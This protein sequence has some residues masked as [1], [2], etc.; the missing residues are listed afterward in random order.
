VRIRVREGGH[1]IPEE[2]IE[3]RYEKGIFNLFE[4]YLNIVDRALIFD[5]SS[6]KHE[7]M[8]HKL[9][10]KKLEIINLLKFNQLKSCYVKNK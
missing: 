3:R 7:I 8:A 10:S 1:N 4:I 2:V 9:E 5:N 6:G